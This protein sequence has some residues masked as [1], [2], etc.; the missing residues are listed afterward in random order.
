M[1]DKCLFKCC[2]SSSDNERLQ[3]SQSCGRLYSIM[4][5]SE[6]HGDK[7]H[8]DFQ[9][10][11]ESYSTYQ[12]KYHKSCVT[13]Y[14]TKAT[15]SAG[16]QKRAASSPSHLHEKRTRSNAGPSFD[17]LRQSFYCR[18]RCSVDQDPKNPNRWIPS[19]VVRETEQKLNNED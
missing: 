12:S 15:R 6:I 3:V 1:D 16:K 8:S 7:L 4:K 14:L 13:K 5:A 19:Y 10:K 18:G 2:Y 17:W 9:T 11:L